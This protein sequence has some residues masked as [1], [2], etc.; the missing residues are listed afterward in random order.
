[1]HNN[2]SLKFYW[3]SKAWSK[4]IIVIYGIK[5]NIVHDDLFLNPCE[6]SL[7][8]EYSIFFPMNSRGKRKS[9]RARNRLC[10]STAVSHLL[11]LPLR[12][13][14]PRAPRSFPRPHFMRLL[15]SSGY[16]TP[17]RLHSSTDNFRVLPLVEVDHATLFSGWRF[18]WIYELAKA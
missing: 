2:I 17:V 15:R 10:Y 11:A 3:P 7:H 14:L 12:V 8:Y 1:M 4:E 6:I 18:L 13:S 5:W 16:H 9:E